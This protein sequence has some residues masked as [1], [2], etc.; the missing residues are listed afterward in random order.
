M[1]LGGENEYDANWKPRVRSLANEFSPTS[2]HAVGMWKAPPLRGG[3]GASPAIGSIS[4]RVKSTAEM[5]A[6]SKRAPWIL[7]SYL[8]DIGGASVELSGT[9]PLLLSLALLICNYFESYRRAGEKVQMHPNARC[10]RGL[11]PL[12]PNAL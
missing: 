3:G 10:Q 5:E 1:K 6:I 9:V 11:K 12:A 8:G 2:K 4:S 7:R